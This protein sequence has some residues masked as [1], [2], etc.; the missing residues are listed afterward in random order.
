MPIARSVAGSAPAAMTA[1][2]V[3]IHRGDAIVAAGL[4][5]H[6]MQGD[7]VLSSVRWRTFYNLR[8]ATMSSLQ[9]THHSDIYIVDHHIVQMLDGNVIEIRTVSD[10]ATNIGLGIRNWGMLS[11]DVKT[12]TPAELPAPLKDVP[13]MILK[14]KE[15]PE[16]ENMPGQ[17]PPKDPVRN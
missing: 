10:A 4:L 1:I 2:A 17:P 9:T 12:L 14:M 16:N 5:L 15:G 11:I 3:Q 7:R 13:A 6:V 8:G